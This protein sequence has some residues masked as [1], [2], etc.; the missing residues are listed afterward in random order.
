MLQQSFLQTLT[1]LSSVG[2]IVCVYIVLL[3]VLW[4]LQLLTQ[5]CLGRWVSPYQLKTWRSV[6]LGTLWVVGDAPLQ[7]ITLCAY[8]TSCM[9]NESVK[10]LAPPPKQQQSIFHGKRGT[11][12]RAIA[13]HSLRPST[14][15]DHE[16]TTA[17]RGGR[18]G[19]VSIVG[20]AVSAQ[21]PIL[22]N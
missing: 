9:Y 22:E 6:T 1:C 14:S 11:Y 19:Q 4:P 16:L 5:D 3:F 21:S 10:S 17:W 18:R 8:I 15:L 13:I 7:I 2:A 12:P 20:V